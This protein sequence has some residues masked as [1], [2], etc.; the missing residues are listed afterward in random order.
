MGDRHRSLDLVRAGVETHLNLHL[1]HAGDAAG[2][3]GPIGTPGDP[4]AAEGGQA[5]G[6]PSVDGAADPDGHAGRV[7]GCGHGVD[8]G[9]GQL[10]AGVGGPVLRPEGAAHFE[11]VV[12]QAAATVEVETGGLVFGALPTHA[13]AQVE[14]ATGQHVQGGGGLR[15][16][17]WS[18]KGGQEDS[19]LEADPVGSGG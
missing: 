19:R 14:S 2:H 17:D 18:A 13:D 11:A 8:T 3:V 10:V 1:L 9:E 7:H 4:A 5:A 12:Q 16:N 6:R 15:E